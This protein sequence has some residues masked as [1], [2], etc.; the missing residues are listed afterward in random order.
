ML[1][2]KNYPNVSLV[3][4][5]NSLHNVSANNQNAITE[6]SITNPYFNKTM[7]TRDVGIQISISLDTNPTHIFVLT[8]H[9][10][11]GNTGLLYQI[12]KMWSV[13]NDGDELKSSDIVNMPSGKPVRYIKDFSEFE[14]EKRNNLIDQAKEDC[15]NGIS[16]FLVANT[17]PL[18]KSIEACFSENDSINFISAIDDNHG[19]IKDYSGTK[20]SV[21]NVAT[22]DNSSFVKPFLNKLISDEMWKPCQDC[23]KCSYC[24]INNNRC[25]MSASSEKISD[26]ITN[27]YIYQLEYGKKLTI[28]Q[29]VAHLSF[30]IT[31]GL[32]CKNIRNVERAKFLYLFVNNFFGY[33]GLNINKEALNMNAINDIVEAAYDNKRLRADEKLFIKDDLSDNFDFTIENML[34]AEGARSHYCEEWQRAVRRAYMML[35]IDTD[36]TANINLMQDVFSLWFPRYLQLRNGTSPASRDK[37]LIQDALQM[38]FT[39]SIKSK[40]NEIPV[41]M[42]RDNG[43]TQCVQLVYDSK[44]KKKIKIEPV[45][46]NDFCNSQKRYNIYVSVDGV[47]IDTRLSLPLFDYFEEIRRGAIATDIDPMLSQGIDSLKAQIIS[48]CDSDKSEIELLILTESC[49]ETVNAEYEN[50]EWIIK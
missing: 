44:P 23:D 48:S 13:I 10:G 2:E 32:S 38:L 14:S 36:A 39:E 24:A 20:M 40:E 50:Q 1:S 37:D 8:G 16:T 12:L 41:T 19:E 15:S 34:R 28:R 47:R 7:V 6:L 42:K 27:H 11:D 45:I 35:N 4:Y 26:F 30:T 33:K 21:I 17:G 5:L 25:L 46:V 31:G 43:I 22:I 9:A 29:I 18:I 3:D 49:W